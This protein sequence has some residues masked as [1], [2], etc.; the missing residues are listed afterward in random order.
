M[1][2]MNI[3]KSLIAVGAASALALA[4]CSSSA[5]KDSGMKERGDPLVVKASF[6]PLQYLVEQIGGDLVS[7]D[8]LTPPGT[9]AHSLELSPKTVSELS[10][11][12][13]V[14]Y[15]RGFQTAV[16]E[17]VDQAK[18][19]HVLD[20]TESAELM[21]TG[22]H[23]HH[24][25]DDEADHDH[26]GEDH[27]H[28]AEGHD[29][30][31]ESHEGEDHDHAS[32]PHEADHDHEAGH[33]D[34]EHD[35]DH[36]GEGHDHEHNMAGDPHFWL[37]PARMEQVAKQINKFLAETDP[38]HAQEYEK[39]TNEVVSKLKDLDKSVTNSFGNCALDTFVVSHEA[40]GYLAAKT[41]LHQVGVSGLEPEVTPSPQRLK[42]IS[43]V[44]KEN[45][46]KVIYAEANVSPK[47]IEVLAHDLG[48]E[49]LVLDPG[50]TQNDPDVDYLQIMTKNLENLKKGLDCK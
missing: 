45:G 10:G 15:L 6:Y 4:G 48:I 42:E 47:A 7:V 32:E 14:V 50:A 46:V 33:E 21:E 40:F 25:H 5:T 24:H 39:N 17:A 38:S 28:E 26:E 18:P 27:D 23:H 8:S 30:E 36:E 44:V 2:V 11:A 34:E 1:V 43:D 41:G 19:S 22:A 49:T 35:H 20:V 3:R 29:H 37:D 16:D 13:A 12:D 9:D 31:A